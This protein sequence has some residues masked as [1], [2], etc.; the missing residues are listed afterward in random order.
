MAYRRENGTI[1]IRNEL[2]VIVTVGCIGD[3][4]RN[5]VNTFR[6]ASSA[7]RH[8]RH[9]HPLIIRSGCS[10]M[11]QDHQNT[12]KILQD[13]VTHPNAGGVLVLGLGCENNQLKPFYDRL[14]QINP[15]RVRCLNC[16]RRGK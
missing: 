5:I 16:P 8:R 2:W 10:Q 11:G 12:V 4:A 15:Q 9:L 6:A 13:I 14:E 3:T 7:G 1:G